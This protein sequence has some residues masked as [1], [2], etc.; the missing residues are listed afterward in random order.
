MA[1]G[2]LGHRGAR[3]AMATAG[4]TRQSRPGAGIVPGWANS[5]H[6]GACGFYALMAVEGRPSSG[7][8]TDVQRPAPGRALNALVRRPEAS[9]TDPIA[10]RRPGK[11]GEPFLLDMATTTVAAGKIRHKANEKL[12]TPPGWSDTA[13]RTRAP[14]PL[15]RLSK[16]GFH[17]AARRH[18]RVSSHKGYGN[19]RPW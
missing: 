6:F 18:A 8:V 17:D 11:P 7:L 9:D 5:A 2:G 3:L 13:K 1:G 15:V 4:S 19:R 10:F 12:P 14:D 16:G